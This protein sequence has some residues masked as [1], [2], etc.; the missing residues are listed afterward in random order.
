MDIDS[1]AKHF[2]KTDPIMARLAVTALAKDSGFELPAKRP[3][4]LYFR[5][6]LS[7]I[8]SQQLSTKAADTIWNRFEALAGQPTPKNV[9]TIPHN[10]LRAVGMSHAKAR[11]VLGLA[12]DVAAGRL[13][14]DDIDKLDDEAVI[15]RLVSVKGIGRWSAEMFL[16]FTLARPDV[17]SLG[18]L[19]LLRSVEELYGRP[20]ITPVELDTLSRAWAPHRTSAALLLWHSRDNK[21]KV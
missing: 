12:D 20:G 9:I 7:S 19:G 18:D 17:F 6:L 15:G 13:K 5:S 3:A 14:L 10:K 21:P 11:Y 4:D 2:A 1:A 16:M 8:V